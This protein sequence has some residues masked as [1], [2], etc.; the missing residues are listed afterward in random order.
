MKTQGLVY[1]C[2]LVRAISPVKQREDICVDWCPFGQ[3]L[4]L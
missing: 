2:D 4:L 3:S 1:L